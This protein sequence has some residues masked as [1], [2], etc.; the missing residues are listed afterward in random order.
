MELSIKQLKKIKDHPKVL[1][2]LIHADIIKDEEDFEKE[3]DY[4]QTL[5]NLQHELVKLQDWVEK[6]QKRVLIIFEGRD[7][8]GKGGTIKRMTEYLDP[9]MVKISALPTPTDVEKSQWY[10]QRYLAHLPNAGEIMIFDRSWYNRA[11]VEPVFGFCTEEQ[12]QLFLNQVLTVEKMIQDDGIIL[13]KLFLSISKDEQQ[14]RLESRGEEYLKSWKLGRLDVQAIEKWDSYSHYIS[15]MF[16]KTAVDFSPWF[17]IETD[18]KRKSRLEAI[19]T[20][21]DNIDY[22]GK[23]PHPI[24]SE[25]VKKYQ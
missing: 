17:E 21:L 25:I 3:F 19:K 13:I 20:I 2:A 22:E 24:Q 16:A 9:K 11:V 6:N 10:F 1:E 4:D 7:A 14:E 12:H 15:E 8:A 23:V 5:W 18:S